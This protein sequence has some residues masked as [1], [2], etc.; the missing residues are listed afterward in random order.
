MLQTDD[1]WTDAEAELAMNNETPMKEL[2]KRVAEGFITYHFM[3][4][5][6]QTKH[7]SLMEGF[8]TQ[9]NMKKN[10]P[11]ADATKK[12]PAVMDTATSVFQGHK[13]DKTYHEKRVKDRQNKKTSPQKDQKDNPSGS[14]VANLSFAQPGRGGC[15]CCGQRGHAFS[16]CPKKATTSKSQWHINKNKEVQQYNKIVD[17]IVTHFNTNANAS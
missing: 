17:E 5:A 15:C 10:N 16:D 14:D 12:Y 4:N 9:H 6:D 7:G 11:N 3:A 1:K 2:K 13:W 8:K